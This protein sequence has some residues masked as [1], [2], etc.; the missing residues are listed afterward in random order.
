MAVHFSA[1]AYAI[2][3][4]SHS[5]FTHQRLNRMVPAATLY[6]SSVRAVR[7][8]LTQSR[9]RSI[10]RL[11]QPFLR[12]QTTSIITLLPTDFQYRKQIDPL[13]LHAS[14]CLSHR[15]VPNPLFS[16]WRLRCWRLTSDGRS[17]PQRCR[18]VGQVPPVHAH[19]CRR[20]KPWRCGAPIL[21]IFQENDGRS[22]AIVEKLL[23]AC[24]DLMPLLMPSRCE[25]TSVVQKMRNALSLRVH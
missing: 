13:F 6:P 22:R 10:S 19:S 12:L 4:V 20:R 18:K 11:Y 1:V 23:R 24:I 2:A 17:R 3:R 5:I 16:V 25:N 9:S 15:L 8:C 14:Q 21:P 7:R